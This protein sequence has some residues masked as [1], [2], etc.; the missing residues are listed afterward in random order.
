VAGAAVA[1]DDAGDVFVA[2]SY[3]GSVDFGSGALPSSP[4]GGL[5]VAKWSAT[6]ASVWSRGYSTAGAGGAVAPAGASSLALSPSGHLFVLGT[7]TDA[8]PLDGAAMT[9]AGPG[10]FILELSP[11]GDPILVHPFTPEGG[12]SSF[13]SGGVAVGARGDVAFAGG[14]AGVVDFSGTTL[15]SAGASDVVIGTLTQ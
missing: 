6:G 13:T 10:S 3:T 8:F 4:G 7:A 1:L 15:T 2:G 5:F 11:S 12:A 14:L 9:T